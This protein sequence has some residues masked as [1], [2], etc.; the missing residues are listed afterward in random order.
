MTLQMLVQDTWPI[1]ATSRPQ[2]ATV[3]ERAGPVPVRID[4]AAVLRLAGCRNPAAASSGVW[5]TARV[6]ASLASQLSAPRAWLWCGPIRRMNPD[7]TLSL[8][9][10]LQFHSRALVRLLRR[11]QAGVLMLLTIGPE[12]EQYVHELMSR[13]QGLEALMLDAA[14]SLCVHQAVHA[15]RDHLSE[16]AASEGLALTPRLAPGYADWPLCE[17]R[18]VFT[19]FDRPGLPV[20]LTGGDQLLPKKS[21]T[22]LWGLRKR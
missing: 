20:T 21:V 14:G 12:L 6:M 1:E 13:Q 11:A 10:D 17:Q 7:G 8:A 9:E 2:P 4:A 5:E 22:G 19:R 16:R 3:L 15:L 18:I